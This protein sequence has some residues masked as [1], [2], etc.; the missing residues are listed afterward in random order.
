[1][2]LSGFKQL[3]LVL[4]LTAILTVG[5][6]KDNT[7]TKDPF[8][9]YDANSPLGKELTYAS[10]SCAGTE[11]ESNKSDFESI[12]M[13][14]MAR[15]G[16]TSTYTSYKMGQCTG[17][18]YGANDIVAL[19][20]HCITEAM[21]NNR[22]R[23]GE[24]L[25]IRFPETPGH[26]TEIR[27]CTELIYKSDIDNSNVF[28]VKPDYA[29]FRIRPV[30]RQFLPLA[31][32]PTGTQQSISVR[33]IN[34][35]PHQNTIGGQLDYARCQ[36]LTG[37]LL[38]TSYRSPWSE[39]GAA[40]KTSNLNQSCKIIQG[41]SGSPVLNA[42]NE[43]IGFAQSYALPEF[44]KIIQSSEF[45]EAFS[46]AVK[47]DIKFSVPSTLPDHFQYTQALCVRSPNSID[48]PNTTCLTNLP[49]VVSDQEDATTEF[50]N[51][52][53][54]DQYL[55]NLKTTLL[56]QRPS[57]FNFDFEK[58]T[59]SE[60]QRYRMTPKCLVNA[61]KWN[62]A[63]VEQSS[64]SGGQKNIVTAKRPLFFDLSVE[65]KFDENLVQKSKILS[66]KS[67]DGRFS[68]SLSNNQI[69][70]LT[71]LKS[72]GFYFDNDTAESMSPITWCN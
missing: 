41:N 2:A 71:I 20:S 33:K 24:I 70:N 57:I 11:C 72:S 44:L 38:N 69:T 55:K 25:A 17:F 14:A 65:V 7:E 35:I 3:S 53:T 48:Y 54:I 32:T 29:F 52:S 9:V 5:C 62:G 15:D 45:S 26:P 12:G 50:D 36:T 23:C 28:N 66:H 4:G 46:K 30:N 22:S 49:K 19:N 68:F 56:T 61:K 43:V 18:L 27:S 8:P 59:S 34:P 37:S 6:S 16:Y 60:R 10:L 40:I 58:D 21:W 64:G 31:T 47:I 39:T 51:A 1:M 42:R 63:D 13:V 67:T